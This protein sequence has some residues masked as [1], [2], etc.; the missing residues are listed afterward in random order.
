MSDHYKKVI[1]IPDT[2]SLKQVSMTWKGPR[3]GQDTDVYIFEELD[4]NNN[5]VAIY[6][7][8]ASTSTYPPF[9]TEYSYK[10]LR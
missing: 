8:E 9:N 3:K 1:G 5:V 2:H 7:F 10:I 4:E 6:E